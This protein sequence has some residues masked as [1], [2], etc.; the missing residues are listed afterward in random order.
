[1][2][3]SASPP[4]S[5]KSLARAKF[6]WIRRVCSDDTLGHLPCRVAALLLDHINLGSGEAWPSQARLA[7][8][9]GVS[10]RAIQYALGSLR[11]SGHLTVRRSK[12]RTN[13]Y[14]PTL[15][16]TNERSNVDTRHAQP[17]SETDEL[18][19]ARL[20]QNPLE[21]RPPRPSPEERRRL[22]VEMHALA[23]AIGSDRAVQGVAQ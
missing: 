2:R 18:V 6:I 1:M 21:G 15:P 23:R 19:F 22:S 8:A 12:G 17:R 13:R 14:R 20:Q 3:A 7:E 16:P 5:S 10:P 9:A 11:A 4:A